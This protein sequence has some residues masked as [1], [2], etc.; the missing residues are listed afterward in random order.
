VGAQ[1]QVGLVQNR[2]DRIT[3]GGFRKYNVTVN[4]Q[5]RWMA[6]VKLCHSLS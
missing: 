1:V 4:L 6:A 3:R 2:S 5:S